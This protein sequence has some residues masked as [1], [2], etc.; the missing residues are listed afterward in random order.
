MDEV[1]IICFVKFK[2]LA[3]SDHLKM[4]EKLRIIVGG[5]IGLYPTGGVTW[6]YIQ[7]PLGLHLLGHDVYYIEDTEQYSFYRSPDR[8]WD[9]PTETIEFLENT[10]NKFGLHDRWGY[11]DIV[12]GIC[13]GLPLDK[14]MNICK[15]ADVFINISAS[16]K[17]REEYFKIPKRVLIDS[18]P[19]FTQV[20]DWDDNNSEESKLAMQQA[21][22]WYSHLFSFGENINK[23]DSRIPTFDLKWCETR[24]PVCL[25]FWQ[26][27]D[28]LRKTE[29][30][31]TVMN[32]AT[33]RTMKYQQEEWGQ[34]DIEF[35]KFIN[36]PKI[37][38]KSSFKIIVAD[39]SEKMD[40]SRLRNFGWE[41]IDPLDTINTADK[42]Q[43]F[44]NASL[45]E[46][47]VAKETYV[48]SNSGWFSC[49]SA[50]YLAAGKPVIT[51]DT[52]WSKYIPSGEGL[53]A[54]NDLT[55]AINALEI[56]T[57]DVKKH[58]IKAR[59]IAEEYFDSNKVLSK[60][61]EALN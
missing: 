7:Y 48:K 56:V 10:M 21:F 51:Q 43:S 2:L 6:D 8:S 3:S 15:T 4:K 44:I 34:K 17:L 14:I 47:S 24:Q 45:G 12:T 38:K 52:T 1:F 36:V 9:D 37:F 31:T 42:Y 27:N 32:W 20:E 50:C 29:A 59:E 26:N 54:F 28:P 5:Y 25:D 35:E 57:A 40:Y 60:L 58:S 46:F 22:S 18:D 19:M 30:L 61:L 33:T 49:R 23:A 55:S 11:R 53:I 41:I 39:N 16:T 13:Y